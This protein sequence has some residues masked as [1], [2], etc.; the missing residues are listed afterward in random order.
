MIVIRKDGE[1]LLKEAVFVINNNRW[2]WKTNDVV[3]A[4]KI[5]RGCHGVW[6]TKKVPE[7]KGGDDKKRRQ[8]WGQTNIGS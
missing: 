5:E 8:S 7:S 3:M 1:C 4:M 6:L 2:G